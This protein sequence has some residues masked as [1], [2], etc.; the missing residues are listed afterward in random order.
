M[1]FIPIL[2]QDYIVYQ[3]IES[4]LAVTS[5]PGNAVPFLYVLLNNYPRGYHEIDILSGF[6]RFQT[7]SLC[8]Q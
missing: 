8:S 5:S 7:Y 4:K 1:N 6:N 2:T 3:S